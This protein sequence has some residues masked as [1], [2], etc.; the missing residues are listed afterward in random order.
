V[1]VVDQSGNKRTLS[2]QFVSAQGLAWWPDGK[3]IW[4]TATTSGSSR[5]LRAVT[6]DG[7]ERLVYLG[8]GTLTL[9]DI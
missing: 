5:E 1:A 8:T 4:F 7:K 2:G 9:Q 6:V 3:E